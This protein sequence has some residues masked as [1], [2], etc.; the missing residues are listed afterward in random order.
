MHHIHVL[1]II[2]IATIVSGISCLFSVFSLKKG[3]EIKRGVSQPDWCFNFI[4]FTDLFICL[5]GNSGP[6]VGGFSPGSPVFLHPLIM[7]LD[8]AH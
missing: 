1:F 5:F 2:F 4:L 8:A 6:V 7:V 3:R